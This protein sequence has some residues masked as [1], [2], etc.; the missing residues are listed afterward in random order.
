MDKRNI[1]SKVT[2]K[3][4]EKPHLK[5]FGNVSALTTGGSLSGSENTGNKAGFMSTG[6]DRSLK[7][8]IV[9]IG[10]HYLGFGLYLFDYKP[11]L[12]DHLDLAID[13]QFGVMAD[14]VEKIMPEAVAVHPDGYKMVN[15]QM[16]G[17]NRNLH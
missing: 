5:L 9:K 14:E 8:N 10:D 12:C 17:I 16:L 11:E 3:V 2:K 15:Y 7:Q 4:Y 6:S 13:R 1:A